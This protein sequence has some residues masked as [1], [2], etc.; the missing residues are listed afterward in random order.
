[1]NLLA[2]TSL[3]FAQF[4]RFGFIG[5]GGIVTLIHIVLFVVVLLQIL[6]GGGSATHK[7]V[8]ILIVLCLPCLGVILWYLVGRGST[9]I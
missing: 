2:E 8:W 1:M 5:G 7:L 9:R 4:G 3:L 6:G